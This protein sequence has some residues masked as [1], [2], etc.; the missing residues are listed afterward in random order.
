M[1]QDGERW[2]KMVQD[3]ARWCKMVQDGARWVKIVQDDARWCKILQDI[4]IP[5]NTMQYHNSN[6][7][8]H[9]IPNKTFN[10]HLFVIWKMM[11][12]MIIMMRKNTKRVF[13]GKGEI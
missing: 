3:G 4:A 11:M 9:T 10:L 7:I 13:E 1:V 5:C 6:T 2:C 12:V 8:Q